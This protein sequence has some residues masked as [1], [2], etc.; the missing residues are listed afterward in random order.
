MK[1][2]PMCQ[3]LHQQQQP[4]HQ[5]E[6]RKIKLWQQMK[7]PLH[8]RL[9]QQMLRLKKRMQSRFRL[10]TITS[11]AK[12]SPPRRGDLSKLLR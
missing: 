2:E 6:M 4:L 1:R 8:L 7:M 5:E 11:L 9:W 10:D 12:V 3:E